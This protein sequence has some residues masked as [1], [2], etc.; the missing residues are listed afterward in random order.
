MLKADFENLVSFEVLSHFHQKYVSDILCNSFKIKS[1]KSICLILCVLLH[2][3]ALFLYCT[4]SVIL[5][6]LFTALIT[7]SPHSRTTFFTKYN[8]SKWIYFVCIAFK[9]LI[10]SC[11]FLSDLALHSIILHLLSVHA[12]SEQ[13]SIHFLVI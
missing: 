3:P 7:H 9:L 11:R 13:L 8:S 4:T 6:S 1:S 5:I 12:Y 2:T 10:I